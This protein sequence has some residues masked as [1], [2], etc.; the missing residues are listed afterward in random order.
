VKYSR[1]RETPMAVISAAIS[2]RSRGRYAIRSDDDGEEGGPSRGDREH[3]GQG[4]VIFLDGVERPGTPPDHER[5]RRLAKL[6]SRTMPY[7]IV[8]PARSGRTRSRVVAVQPA[9]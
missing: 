8:Y 4:Q 1:N 3:G 6:M 5:R 9:C 7:T 2:E